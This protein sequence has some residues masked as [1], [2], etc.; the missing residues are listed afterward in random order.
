MVVSQTDEVRPH[1]L[2]LIARRKW[3]IGGFF[4]IFVVSFVT[5]LSDGPVL[6]ILHNVF[7]WL[8]MYWTVFNAVVFLTSRISRARLP[9]RHT[10]A[11][12]TTGNP[13]HYPPRPW[14]PSQG[15]PPRGPAV[16]TWQPYKLDTDP[17]CLN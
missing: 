14:H 4:L 17:P 6:D 11:L 7:I 15:P 13:T 12:L 16:K 8:L 9:Y 10:Q 1:G 3:E 5:A 2:S